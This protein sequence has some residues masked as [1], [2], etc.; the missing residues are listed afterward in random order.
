LLDNYIF[1]NIKIWSG[2]QKEWIEKYFDFYDYFL[3]GVVQYQKLTESHF[4][5]RVE[6]VGII[7]GEEAVNWGLSGPMLR[8]F[9]IQRDLH[10]IISINS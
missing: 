7:G 8:A 6:W 4:L 1:F 10:E 5:E 2:A 3:T 9:G